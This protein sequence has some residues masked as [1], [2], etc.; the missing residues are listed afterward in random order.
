[1]QD[2]YA[3]DVG[4]FGKYGLLRCLTATDASAQSLRLAVL[5]YFVAD[6]SHNNDGRHISY[7]KDSK[8]LFRSCDPTLFSQMDR[9]VSKGRSLKAIEDSG[10]LPVGTLFHSSALPY[11]AR[12]RTIDRMA[13]RQA[14][15]REAAAIASSADLVFLDPDNGLECSSVGRHSKTGTKYAYFD[16]VQALS[17]P[18][19]SLLIY[20]HL[21]RQHAAPKQILNRAQS[22]AK[23]VPSN[24]E[25]AALRY[26]RGSARVFFVAVAP[27]HCADVALRL[28]RF[29]SSP[30]AAHFAEQPLAA[31][32]PQQL[33]RPD[34]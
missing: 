14:W 15:I 19:T 21:C 23:H 17:T 11:I 29:L 9:I 32:G 7:L 28:R 2:R 30:W 20:H 34:V 31:L 4:D 22:L 12:E 27:R 1:M 33:L 6:E 8:G 24:H 25:I 3:G 5:W 10:L 26:R 16:D 18:T 13:K